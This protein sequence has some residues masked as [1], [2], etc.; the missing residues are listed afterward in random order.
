MGIATGYAAALCRKYGTN[1]RGVYA[2]HIEELRSLVEKGTVD[3]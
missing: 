3:P 2:D 1:P